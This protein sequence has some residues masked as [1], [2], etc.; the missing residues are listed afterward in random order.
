MS[1]PE[2]YGQPDHEESM[3]SQVGGNG[4]VTIEGGGSQLVLHPGEV[5]RLHSDQGQQLLAQ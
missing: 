3:G 1:A 5:R 4:K 2:A